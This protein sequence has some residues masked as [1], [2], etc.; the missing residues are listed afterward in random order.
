M[1]SFQHKVA[2]I[3]GAAS[4]IGRGMAQVF[5]A[6]GMRVVLSDV[7]EAALR[8][9]AEALR[10]AGADVHAVV[11]DV[12]HAGQVQALAD[13]AVRH[14]G[15]VDLLCNNAGV[16]AGTTPSW[17]STLDDWRWVMGVNLMGVVHG[18]RSFMPIFLAQGTPAHIVNTASMAGLSS[19]GNPL[20]GASKAAVVSLSESLYLELQ[21]NRSNVNVSLLCPGFVATNILGAERNRPAVL[22]DASAAPTS[23][24]AHALRHWFGEQVAQG[25]DPQDVARQVLDAVREQRFYVFTHPQWLSHVEHRMHHLLQGHNP[26]ASPPPGLEEALRRALSPAARG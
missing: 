10:D 2:V 8:R 3:T 14:Y 12:A 16:S 21:R 11:A 22:A 23:P 18:I 4:G 9:T 6:A 25:L 17:E 19:G 7:E 5:A 15:T 24:V 1:D 13:A 26:T 20:Y